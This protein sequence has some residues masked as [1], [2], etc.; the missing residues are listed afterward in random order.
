MVLPLEILVTVPTI[1]TVTSKSVTYC[2][3][4]RLSHIP[5]PFVCKINTKI[6]TQN[7]IYS[8]LK[9]SPGILSSRNN[10]IFISFHPIPFCLFLFLYQDGYNRSRSRVQLGGDCLTKYKIASLTPQMN[11]VIPRRAGLY[12]G[13][14][15]QVETR[16]LYKFCLQFLISTVCV[17]STF[18]R[19]YYYFFSYLSCSSNLALAA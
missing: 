17:V 9:R 14:L 6:T 16:P 5:V 2:Y 11:S 3:R 10:S 18:V 4:A 1:L 13:D 7:L 12:S 15:T 19:R 8:F